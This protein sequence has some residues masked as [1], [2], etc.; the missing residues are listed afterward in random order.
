MNSI[1][2]DIGGTKTRVA[3]SENGENF[4]TPE[5]YETPK[6]YEDGLKLF[7]E[8]ARSVTKGREIKN[9][10]GG[11][12][13][14]FDEKKRTLVGSPNLKEWIGHP[15]KQ[16]LEKEFGAPVYIENDS[17]VV[18]LGEANYGA[19]KDFKIVAYLTIST[20]VGGARII[21][22][23]IDE[24]AI[25]FEPGHQI[26]DADKTIFPDVAGI[27]A[28]YVLSGNGVRVRTGKSPK[29]INDPEFWNKMSQYLSYMLNN[30]TVM[31]SPD[32]I[33]LGGSMITG[34]PAIPLDKTEQYLKEILKIFPQIPT[35][36]KAELGD[37]GGLWGGLA[38]LK[39]L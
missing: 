7:I 22:G 38:Y 18:A 16:D 6:N 25:G 26:I 29:E 17:A 28:G 36:K 23:K 34:D 31:W 14:P 4:E 24:K 5:V 32:L 1:L 19:G 11:I 9:I 12:A 35:I 21:D 13:G 27:H 8:K 33:V 20:G 10:A 3:Y 30:I 37:F 39:T 15:L 2:F